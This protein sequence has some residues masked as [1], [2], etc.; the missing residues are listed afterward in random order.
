MELRLDMKIVFLLA[1]KIYIFKRIRIHTS[2]S[3]NKKSA[4][5][6]YLHN[7]LTI[8]KYI[9]NSLNYRPQN[10]SHK[11]CINAVHMAPSLMENEMMMV[12]GK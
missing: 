5:H 9:Y 2:F 3:A 8:D 1:L 4:Q 11:G 10:I 7:I 12:T 6:I